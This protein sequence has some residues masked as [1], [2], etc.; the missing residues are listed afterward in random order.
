MSNKFDIPTAFSTAATSVERILRIEQQAQ[1]D[2]DIA[3]A[4][5]MAGDWTGI[6]DIMERNKRHGWTVADLLPSKPPVQVVIDRDDLLG[7]FTERVESLTAEM[8]ELNSIA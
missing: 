5:A 6:V 2:F 8:H 1:A 3:W 7:K 4:N